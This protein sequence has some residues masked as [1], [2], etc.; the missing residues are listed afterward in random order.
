M[1][2]VVYRARRQASAAMPTSQCRRARANSVVQGSSAFSPTSTTTA[3]RSRIPSLFLCQVL[4]DEMLVDTQTQCCL[5]AAKSFNLDHVFGDHVYPALPYHNG[6]VQP[7]NC[8]NIRLLGI[9]NNR[10]VALKPHFDVKTYCVLCWLFSSYHA[11]HD[12]FEPKVLLSIRNYVIASHPRPRY[13]A[14]VTERPIRT[15]ALC[16]GRVL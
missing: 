3:I 11:R 7:L 14:S 8:P 4:C 2:S 16:S 13:R 12:I 6:S 1:T 15:P 10:L 9:R 5:I